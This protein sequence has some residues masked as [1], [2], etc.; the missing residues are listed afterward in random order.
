MVITKFKLFC[1]AKLGQ[2]MK[3]NINKESDVSKQLQKKSEEK[4]DLTKDLPKLIKLYNGISLNIKWFN[5]AAHDINQ[6]ISERTSFVN[7]DDFIDALRLE[8]SEVF[9]EKIGKDL[10]KSGKYSIYLEEYNISLIIVFD[11][12]KNID[13]YFI[14]V[15]TVLPGKKGTDVVKI[16]EISS[17]RSEQDFQ[18]D[19][20]D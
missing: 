18:D 20:I 9:P 3:L 4:Y 7:L 5:T 1:E 15:I 14:E 16:I 13:S 2:V 6:R 11:L 8:L 12:N 19:L 10:F 17:K